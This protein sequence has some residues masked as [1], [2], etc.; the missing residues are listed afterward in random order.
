MK[1]QK[2]DYQLNQREIIILE[3]LTKVLYCQEK[4][5]IKLLNLGNKNAKDTVYRII[6]KLAQQDFVKKVGLIRGDD[7]FILINKK[8]AKLFDIKPPKDLILNTL[9]HDMLVIDL[10]LKLSL[11]DSIAEIKTDK[12]LKRQF[13]MRTLNNKINFPDLLIENN[14]AIEVEISDKGETRL[15]EIINSYILNNQINEVHYYIKSLALARKIL[16]ICNL[17]NKFKIFH[18][19]DKIEESN[20]LNNIDIPG[21]ENK[22]FKAP[23]FG[24]DLEAFLKSE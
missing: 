1:N 10:Y 3:F 8:A 24:F 11:V 22:V 21:L 18:F 4:H 16:E 12:E 7:Y 6:L 9:K 14:I 23:K 19:V 5:L 20:Q 13:G 15:K 2:L 17:N